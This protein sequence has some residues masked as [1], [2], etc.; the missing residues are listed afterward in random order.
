MALRRVVLARIHPP[1]TTRHLLN[2]SVVSDPAFIRF[3][4][5]GRRCPVTG[6]SRSSLYQ[7]VLPSEANGYNPP[8][9][10]AVIKNRCA[11]RGVRLVSVPSLL[12]YLNSL[13]EKETQQTQ[14]LH[15]EKTSICASPDCGNQSAHK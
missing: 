11:A 4:K 3:P 14:Q 10:S 7:L 2:N 6:L 12:G 8:V 15:L 5:P 13:V 1:M 9:R